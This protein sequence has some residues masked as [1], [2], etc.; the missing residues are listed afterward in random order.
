MGSSQPSREDTVQLLPALAAKTCPAF[1]QRPVSR[2]VI[3]AGVCVGHVLA[4]KAHRN[5]L[6]S[7]N[8]FTWR[9]S[10]PGLERTMWQCRLL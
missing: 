10:S 3:L 7:I 4:N 8:V 6:V 9:T 1:R 2:Y 5:R